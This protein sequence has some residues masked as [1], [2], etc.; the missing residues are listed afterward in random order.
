MLQ[1]TVAAVMLAAVAV[2]PILQ[3]IIFVYKQPNIKNEYKMEADF[4]V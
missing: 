1:S 3:L 2:L 4:L